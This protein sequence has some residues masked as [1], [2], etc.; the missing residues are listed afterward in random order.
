M[1]CVQLLWPAIEYVPT[2]QVPLMAVVPVQKDPAGQFSQRQV[3][4]YLPGKH[5]VSHLIGHV[6]KPAELSALTVYIHILQGLPIANNQLLVSVK[7]S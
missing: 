3:G 5:D 1:H 4:T 6:V 7:H 2:L